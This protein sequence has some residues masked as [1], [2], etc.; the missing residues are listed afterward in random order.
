ML[1][2]FTFWVLEVNLILLAAFHG[3]RECTGLE[4][5]FRGHLIQPS[6]SKQWQPQLDQIV[7][8]HAKADL[9]CLQE[10]GPH[11]TFLGNLSSVLLPSLW[12]ASSYILMSNLSLLFSR[13]KQL[14]L[15]CFPSRFS[16][17]LVSHVNLWSSQGQSKQS[18]YI[19]STVP[20]PMLRIQVWWS[21]SCC[22]ITFLGGSWEVVAGCL[23]T[24]SEKI[25]TET[26]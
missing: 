11:A 24:L 3:I 18:L 5:T 8:S 21:G 12:R 1:L 14:P 16:S 25:F 4:G 6:C 22:R 2:N 15:Y 9:E 19:L 23:K 13:L 10:W 17:I 20:F 26:S 7:Q